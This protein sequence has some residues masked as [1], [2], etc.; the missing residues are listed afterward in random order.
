MVTLT[1]A[2]VVTLA[3]IGAKL[4][5]LSPAAIAAL[6]GKG[7]DR[8]DA[9]DNALTLSVAQ[10][11][12][13]G[14]VALTAADLATLADSGANLAALSAASI[15]ALAGNGI[16][17]LDATD[18]V[19]SLTVAQVQALGMVA[20]TAA[21]VVTLTDSGASLAALAASDFATLA[22]K[23]IDRSTPRTMC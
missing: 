15:A 20:L 22:G 1:A 8:L 3:D 18:D 5:A 13:L 7:I 23:G 9:T 11:Q 19:L 21:D 16:D 10:F 2:D 6:A 14:V 4:A 12:A 17:R